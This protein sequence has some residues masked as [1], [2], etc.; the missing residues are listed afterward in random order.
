MIEFVTRYYYVGFITH[1]NVQRTPLHIDNGESVA[2]QDVPTPTKD[3]DT[4]LGWYD[5][6]YFSGD[7][8]TFPYTP[9]GDVTLYAKWQNTRIVTFDGNYTN[10]GYAQRPVNAGASTDNLQYGRET[11]FVLV[12]WYDNREGNG[13]AIEFPYYPSGDVTLYAKWAP[14]Y[15]VGLEP[16]ND[17]VQWPWLINVAYG[18][19]I[20][21]P[22]P[23]KEG[24]VLVGWYDNSEFNGDA[25]EF[26][27]EPTGDIKLFAKWAEVYVIRLEICDDSGAYS[28]IS[29]RAGDAIGHLSDADSVPMIEDGYIFDGWYDNDEYVGSAIVAATYVPEGN[30]TL[31]AKWLLG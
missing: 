28:E 11:G 4:L 14:A 27:Y 5:N 6:M 1:D 3:N 10:G 31:Y 22:L 21:M 7:A 15:I 24:F 29:V 25:I 16:N 17:E 19:S 26:P 18:D 20:D 23:N 2:A 9:S 8:I 12:G 13:D 30:M